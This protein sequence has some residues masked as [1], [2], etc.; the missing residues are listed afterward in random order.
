MYSDGLA[1]IF[2]VRNLIKEL[3]EKGVLDE[4]LTQKIL[5]DSINQLSSSL[6]KCESKLSAYIVADESD[7]PSTDLQCVN[8]DIL[9]SYIEGAIE[10]LSSDSD[11]KA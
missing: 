2:L 1:A 6:Q 3:K 8:F 11:Y 5:D 10:I 7:E 9:K 4:V